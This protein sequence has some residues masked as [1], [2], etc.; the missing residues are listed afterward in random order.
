MSHHLEIDTQVA[1][2]GGFQSGITC[3]DVERVG[4]VI[5]FQQLRNV[6]L[7]CLSAELHLQVGLLIEAIAQVERRRDIGHCTYGIHWLSEVVL[8]EVG[9]LWQDG[10]T[11]VHI[12]LL[13]HVAQ[14]DF[15]CMTV[16]RTLRV[17]AQTGTQV[18]LVGIVKIAE[19]CRP[20]A[21]VVQHLCELLFRIVGEVVCEGIVLLVTIAVAIVQL[22][23]E[24]L[25][26]E[27]SSAAKWSSAAA[28][29]SSPLLAVC[30]LLV[31]FGL[32][33]NQRLCV[34]DT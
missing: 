12:D 17:S 22:Q 6:G 18:A 30:R 1:V 13:T 31:F 8:D 11:C 14:L 26:S 2:E 34:C 25:L 5:D 19:E 28:E 16:F 20:V 27:A 32:E 10:D 33:Q 7:L 9:A 15:G 24:S 3:C 23:E 29:R 21:I 4:I